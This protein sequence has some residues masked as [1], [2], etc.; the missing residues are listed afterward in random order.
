MELGGCSSRARVEGEGFAVAV[1]MVLADDG[2][3]SGDSI[4]LHGL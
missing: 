4:G 3:D 1:W 2:D